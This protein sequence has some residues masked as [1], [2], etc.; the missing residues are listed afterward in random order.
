MSVQQYLP[1]SYLRKLMPMLETKV[2]HGDKS[3]GGGG[4]GGDNDIYIKG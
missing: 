3:G 1:L 4:K 2:S